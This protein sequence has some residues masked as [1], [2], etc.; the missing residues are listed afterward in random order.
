[1]VTSARRESLGWHF[2]DLPSPRGP[3]ATVKRLWTETQ[4]KAQLPRGGGVG[5]G[6]EWGIQTGRQGFLQEAALSVGPGVRTAIL[7]FFEN[8][9]A[10]SLGGK[11][12][13]ELCG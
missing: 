10:S 2:T 13:A 11:H 3:I 1:M 7:T 6:G 8:C 12:V 9:V 4:R 5:W